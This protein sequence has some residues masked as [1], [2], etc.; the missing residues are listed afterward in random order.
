[1]QVDG[2]AE[3]QSTATPRSLGEIILEIMD[4]QRKADA[5]LSIIESE[6]QNM[7]KSN[8]ATA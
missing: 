3:S 7:Q 1:M 4:N 8:G 6:L 5:R 2:K